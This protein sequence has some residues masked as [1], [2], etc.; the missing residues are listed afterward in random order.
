[1]KNKDIFFSIFCSCLFILV[2][3]YASFAYVA[4]QISK[5]NLGIDSS[6]GGSILFS[7]TGGN[8][9]ASDI[10]FDDMADTNLGIVANN[11]D[12]ISINLSTSGE[13]L[14]CCNYGIYYTWESNS[15]SYTRTTN[16]SMEYTYTLNAVDSY[17][18]LNTSVNREVKV[19]TNFANYAGSNPTSLL[20]SYNICNEDNSNGGID[21][22]VTQTLSIAV[23]F[24]NIDE[25]QDYFKNKSLAGHFTIG[26][27]ENAST[28]DNANGIT[29][30]NS[31]TY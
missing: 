18:T 26:A 22:S 28:L 25:N 8:T 29:C 15:D 16:D 10:S 20:A 19:E 31:R 2:I 11:T 13:E 9:I 3:G 27:P 4:P 6:V 30:K 14:I 23:K 1:M 17:N 7:A 12:T 5:E 24:Y 21:S